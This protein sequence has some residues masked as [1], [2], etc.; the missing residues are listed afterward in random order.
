MPVTGV[1]SNPPGGRWGSGRRL[2][3]SRRLCHTYRAPCGNIHEPSSLR[4]AH[5][6]NMP[7][8]RYRLR[9]ITLISAAAAAIYYICWRC[10]LFYA[11]RLLR[12]EYIAAAHQAAL[13]CFRGSLRC[14]LPSPLF[15]LLL[16]ARAAM[17]LP[18]PLAQCTNSLRRELRHAL[19]CRHALVLRPVRELYT[20]FDAR[21][22]S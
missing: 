22:R 18:A 5:A 1:A 21:M 2:R 3:P 19:L 7:C 4:C 12:H 14:P 11:M 20:M 16:A 6:F 17:L 9:A 8:L 15:Y 10:Q 13:S